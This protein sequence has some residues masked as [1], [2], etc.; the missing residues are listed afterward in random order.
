MKNLRTTLPPIDIPFTLNHKSRIISIGSCF[1][2]IIGKK[3]HVLKFPVLLNPFGI[4]YNP[5]SIATN[6]QRMLDKRHINPGELH[7]YDNKH[8]SF[9][10]HGSFAGE[11]SEIALE[12]MNA[13]IS[14]GHEQLKSSTLL[15][16]TFG[17]SFVFRLKKTGKVV[18]NCHKL[19]AD[20]FTRSTKGPD[21]IFKLMN[22]IFIK[23]KKINS[24]IQIL[25]TVS[26]VRHLRDGLVQNQKSKAIL[27]LA[28][29]QLAEAFKFVHYFPSYELVLDDLRDYRFYDQDLIHPGSFARGY[30]WDYFEETFFTNDTKKLCS[31]IEKLLRAS[32]HRPLHPYTTS[33]RKFILQQLDILYQLKSEYEFLDLSHEN[34]ISTTC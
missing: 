29:H 5:E 1:A 17:T 31:R 14:D 2:E 16:L 32:N 3:L 25:L 27:L 21:E 23:I 15:I 30:I 4:L 19:P 34:A 8:F 10:F 9:D 24:E 26:P 7:T 22:D 6:L 13:S 33:H 18:A 12:K 20:N 11:T 28:A